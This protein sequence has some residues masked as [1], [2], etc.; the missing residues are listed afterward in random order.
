MATIEHFFSLYDA[1]RYGP[2][3]I[4]T[5]VV[6]NYIELGRLT[7]LRFIQ[8][9][10]RNPR[11]VISLP[12][13]KTPQFFIEWVLHYK[14]NWESSG[15]DLLKK[16]FSDREIQN[17]FS[18]ENLQ[19]VQIDEFFPIQ[20]EQANS[21]NSYIKR[22]YMEGF[23][24]KPENALLIDLE[25]EMNVSFSELFPEGQADFQLHF[26]D[27]NSLTPLQQRQKQFLLEMNQYCDLYEKRIQQLGGIQF[28]LGGIGPD[29]HIGFNIRGSSHYST[30]RLT[31]VNYETQAASAG[32]LGG[33]QKNK[34]VVTIGLK[35]ITRNREA[36]LIIMAAGNAKAGVVQKAVESE[37]SVRYPATALHSH[38]GALFYLTPGAASGLLS[39]EL[40][41]LENGPVPNAG[42]IHRILCQICLERGIALSGLKI[43]HIQD[44]PRGRVLLK[45]GAIPHQAALDLLSSQSA[46]V[47]QKA[48]EHG[49]GT[50][51]P[52]K[53]L[54]TAPHHDDLILGI[55][56]VLE[57]ELQ[58]P[59]CQTWV[60][61]LTS[62]FTAVTNQMLQRLLHLALSFV[63]APDLPFEDFSQQ[64]P[65]RDCNL[66][67]DG[68]AG[69][70]ED[71]ME[72]SRIF[73]LLRDISNQT[74]CLSW[75][76]LRPEVDLLLNQIMASYP[77]QK[78]SAPIQFLKGTLREFE[79]ELLWVSQGLERSRITHARLNFYQ[80]DI[81]N[82]D[83]AEAD[84]MQILKLL[85][86]IQPDRISLALDPEGSGP[87]THFKVLLAISEA[88]D[89]FCSEFPDHQLEILGYRNVWNRFQAYEADM[90]IP[91]TSH[92]LQNMDRAF[93][94]FYFS[95]VDA[96]FPT[97]EY[98]GPFSEYSQKIWIEQFQEFRVLCG[99][100]GLN[101][102]LKQNEGLIYCKILKPEELTQFAKNRK[103]SLKEMG[104]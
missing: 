90:A 23:G 78:D 94:T 72:R 70:R 29:G 71:L 55:F 67:L 30:T 2:E 49:K 25:K 74:A 42:T 10:I 35:T 63:K 26:L 93:K 43:K 47:L 19:F 5:V 76:S 82:Q 41:D 102:E 79:E 104:S 33:I 28:F 87:D 45:K 61:V 32:D 38:P 62:G 15:D 24:I 83:P 12:T 40:T 99:E 100:T 7:A 16:G 56:P 6:S 88:V 84:F 59:G 86:E 50:R 8:W 39:R 89:R 101:E 103:I 85:R 13:G 34:L 65:D 31:P 64:S 22:F 77:G 3:K 48:L 97:P 17:G 57:N 60:S 14:K 27:D 36:T 95:Q 58:T 66:F 44:S 1:Y 92:Q 81:F 73:R 21:F 98:C 20:A 69:S 11:G 37:T 75:E 51:S 9:C 91:M 46:Q 53:S 80:G 18:C 4:N 68:L 52:L 96:P 54:H